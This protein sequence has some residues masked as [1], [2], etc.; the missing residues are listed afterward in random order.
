MKVLFIQESWIFCQ[1][2]LRKKSFS[3]MEMILLFLFSERHRSKV[4]GQ[5]KSNSIIH[6]FVGV[7]IKISIFSDNYFLLHENLFF[8]M[9]EK[10]K[11][12][13]RPL[14]NLSQ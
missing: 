13:L 4:F 6:R 11:W 7:K 12:N 2:M 14:P 10:F 8:F 3:L 5:E 1:I 9:K